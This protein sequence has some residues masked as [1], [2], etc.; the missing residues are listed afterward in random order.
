MPWDLPSEKLKARMVQPNAWG[1]TRERLE[2]EWKN[3]VFPT[4]NCENSLR[5]VEK[6]KPN[7]NLNPIFVD[8]I[9]ST[10]LIEREKGKGSRKN[11]LKMKCQNVKLFLRE[12]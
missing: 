4:D 2:A 12:P 10:A 9:F 1:L 5:A 11:N 8:L 3:W 6:I 7:L